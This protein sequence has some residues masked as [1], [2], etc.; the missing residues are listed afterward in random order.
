VVGSEPTTGILSIGVG[1]L[2]VIKSMTEEYICFIYRDL[3]YFEGVVQNAPTLY[4]TL[5]GILILL[6]SL[7]VG[8]SEEF[9]L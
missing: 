5:R 6:K 8:L 7:R 9:Y 4:L 1:V 3:D 2:S